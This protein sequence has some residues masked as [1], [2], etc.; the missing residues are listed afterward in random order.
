MMVV[1]LVWN[2]MVTMMIEREPRAREEAYQQSAS[3]DDD[4]MAQGWPQAVARYHTR[5]WRARAPP[6]G[7]C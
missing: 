6:S 7:D 2:E 3:D 4:H 1:V 5:W